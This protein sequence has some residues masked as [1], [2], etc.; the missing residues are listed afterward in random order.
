MAR[1]GKKYRQALERIEQQAYPPREAVE[2]LKQIR[3]ESFD[4]TVE[5]HLRL[6]VDPRHADQQV[7]GVALLPHGTGKPVRILVFAEGEAAS[8]AREAGAD[9]VGSEDLV[10]K[11]QG[12]WL[13]FDVAVAIPPVMGKVGRLG[14]I[15]GPRG[16]MPNPK[17]GTVV[18]P[19]DLPRVI[20]EA[21]Q[22][23]VEFRVDKG[24]NLHVPIGKASFA[25]EQ[26]LDNLA[27]VLD[28]VQRARPPAAKGQYVR[29][30]VL[31]TTMSPPVRVDVPAALA[32]SV[33]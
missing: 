20:Q 23:R 25:T 26:L 11:I 16:L 12:G 32:L 21:R 14:K 7:R 6:G 5:L 1:R 28:T 3:P 30:M 33:P 13:D 29:Q 15:L 31:A 18:P 8:I 17:A 10:E 24:A 4:P 2:L 22:G 19:D 27:T 9:H